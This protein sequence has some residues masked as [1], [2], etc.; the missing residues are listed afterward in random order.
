MQSEIINTVVAELTLNEGMGTSVE[1]AAEQSRQVANTIQ[2]LIKKENMLMITQDS[3]F[4]N[5][6][7]VCLNINLDDAN[8][9]GGQ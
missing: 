8:I 5:E 2:H 6:R 1:R 4:K 3:K 9:M 7:L